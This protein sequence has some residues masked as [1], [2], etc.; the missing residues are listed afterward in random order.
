MG[1]IS[2]ITASAVSQLMSDVAY[3]TT[4]AGKTYSA[5]VTY[6]DGEY[7]AQASK[8]AGAEAS[9]ASVQAAEN[10]LTTRISILV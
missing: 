5:D 6:S 10:N 1:S 4:V 7:T 9:G 3:S 2:T 8:L